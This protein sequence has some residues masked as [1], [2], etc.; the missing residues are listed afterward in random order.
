MW[1]VSRQDEGTCIWTQGEDRLRVQAVEPDCLRITQTRREHFILRQEPMLQAPP[2]GDAALRL[3]GNALHTGLLRAA[4]DP[5]TG[6]MTCEA[7]GKL[8]TRTRR[9]LRPI[10]IIRCRFDPNAPLEETLGV[11][12]VRMN[13]RGE[14]YVDRQGY[15]TRLFFDFQEDEALYGLGQHE[16]GILNLRGSHQLL[17]QHNLKIACPVLL[18]T[19]GW[20]ILY[21]SCAAMTFHDD[22][23]GSYLSSDADDEMDYFFFF[24]PSFDRMIA[25][26]RALTG[27]APIPPKWSF[28]YVQSKEHYR[29]QDELVDTAAHYRRLGIPLDAIVQDWNTWADGQWGNKTPEA[30]RYPDIDKASGALHDMH[31]RLMWSIWPNMG[32][33]SENRRAFL[34][35]GLLLGNRST[36]DAFSDR[37]RALY[38]QQ[39]KEGLFDKGIDAWWCDAT[40]PFEADW[41][42][43]E[44]MTPEDRMQ[45]D[46]AVFKKYLDPSL[47]NAYS[48]YHSRGMFEG[49]RAATD[50]KRVLNLTRSGYPGQQRYGTISW[51]GDTSARWDVMK[52]SIA[53]GLNFCVT[54][55][56]YWTMDVGGFFVRRWPQWFGRGEYENGVGDPAYRELY[57]RWFQLGTFLPML[58]SHGTDTPREVWHFG[59]EV[60]AMLTDMIRL[61]TRLV[62]YLYSL[63]GAVYF[64]DDTMLRMLAFDFPQDVTAREVD[65]QFMLGRALLVCPVCAPG[66]D[67]REVYLPDGAGWYDFWTEAYLDGGQ[68]I[69]ADAPPERLPLFVRAGSILPLGP[70]RQY[71]DE[72]S[73]APLELRVYTGADASF[74]LYDDAGDGYGYE[75]GECARVRYR[76]E[77]AKGELRQSVT[78]EEAYAPEAVN[79]RIIG[80]DAV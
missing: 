32:G 52:R 8:L 56:P 63:A 20:G 80:R 10:D 33:D 12:G 4:L 31:V 19:R 28:G 55:Q 15:Q 58:R 5:V 50:K 48:L 75:A 68:W 40:E 14:P 73:E 61:R 64:E 25:R 49:Q 42:G 17:Y 46:V 59:E 34:R 11:D 29:T 79:T 47:I 9:M 43:E 6:E 2:R 18:S 51:N 39:A 21:N 13:A 1:T 67:T 74:V 27:K 77:E 45:C 76:W 22:A 78:G 60:A 26:L 57:L 65:D 16:E 37:A 36:Y 54:G 35:E 70:V 44:P 30:A 38:W 3:Q 71:V 41:Y 62:P 69:L 7:S 53:D 66:A 24:G 23:F 72:P